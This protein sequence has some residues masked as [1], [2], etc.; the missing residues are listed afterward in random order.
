MH[1]NGTLWG[2]DIQGSISYNQKYYLEFIALK[3]S[4]R[5]VLTPTGWFRACIGLGNLLPSCTNF[6]D[7]HQ[8]QPAYGTCLSQQCRTQ[9]CVQFTGHI[10]ARVDILYAAETLYWMRRIHAT[11]LLPS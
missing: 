1:S 6:L 9:R 8:Q 5:S 2:L 3:S 10:A 11:G 7:R 4:P